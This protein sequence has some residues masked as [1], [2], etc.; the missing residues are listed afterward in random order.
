MMERVDAYLAFARPLKYLFEGATPGVPYSPR[1]V[2]NVFEAGLVKAVI[3]KQASVHSLRHA[4]ATRLL[5][6]GTDIR[7]IQELLGH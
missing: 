7:I 2:Q 1:S 3:K 5:E 4:F 6:Q